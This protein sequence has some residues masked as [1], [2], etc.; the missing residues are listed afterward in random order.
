M[1]KFLSVA[2]AVM[3]VLALA[4]CPAFASGNGGGG[5]NGGGNGGGGGNNPLSVV[6]VT[7]DGQALEGAE[8]G[9]D[10]TIVISFD[11]GMNKNYET[12]AA[13]ISIR[14]AESTVSFDGDRSFTVTF[15]GLKEGAYTLVIGANATANN[16]N[17]LGSDYT[18]NFTVKLSANGGTSPHT[19]DASAVYLACA[20]ISLCAAGALSFRKKEK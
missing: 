20:A 12:T 18:V 17:T 8:L 15:S 14:G 2:I 6:S 1:K 10:G 11:R 5:G 7:A 13:A 4:V 3:L 19:F 9:P 16:G